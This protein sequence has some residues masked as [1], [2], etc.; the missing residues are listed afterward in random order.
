MNPGP[1]TAMT[2]AMRMRQLLRKFIAG[3]SG[4]AA[5]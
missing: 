5:S 2:R 1:T 3:V 4:A